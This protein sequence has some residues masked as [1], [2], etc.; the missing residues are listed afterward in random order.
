MEKLTIADIITYI[1][2]PLGGTVAWFF[3]MTLSRLQS[4]VDMIKKEYLHKEDFK[5]FKIELRSMFDELRKDI[6]ALNE[7]A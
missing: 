4:D 5:D 7:K 3:R 2:L 6:R 1:I